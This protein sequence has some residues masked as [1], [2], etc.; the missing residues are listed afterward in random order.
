MELQKSSHHYGDSDIH[1]VRD[2]NPDVV[3]QLFV[4]CPLR[5][6]N[7]NAALGDAPAHGLVELNGHGDG[8]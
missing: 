6:P 2:H 7:A 8:S 5:N 1:H 4:E 3:A